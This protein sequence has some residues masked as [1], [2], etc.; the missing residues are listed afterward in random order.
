M[1]NTSSIYSNSIS[2]KPVPQKRSETDGGNGSGG[3]NSSAKNRQNATSRSGSGTTENHQ[4]NQ[5]KKPKLPELKPT[6]STFKQ[7]HRTA[8]LSDLI[9][10]DDTLVVKPEVTHKNT[11]IIK[12]SRKHQNSN[13]NHHKTTTSNRNIQ[14]QELDTESL[15]SSNVNIPDPILP[16]TKSITV[17]TDEALDLNLEDF[18]I[19]NRYLNF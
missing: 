1:P 5:Q 4:G 9:N 8:S 7:F 14:I 11:N 12:K 10:E 18:G 6:F 3:R 13:Q 16:P 2:G 19:S 17:Q 15:A